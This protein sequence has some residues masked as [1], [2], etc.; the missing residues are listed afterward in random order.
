MDDYEA[1]VKLAKA[2]D[3]LLFLDFT[4]SDWCG[5]CI[6]LKS[7]VFDQR[8]FMKYADENLVLVELDFPKGKKLKKSLQKQNEELAK[9]YG[10][11][12]FPRIIIL[13]AKEEPVGMM[14]YQ[15][16]GPKPFIKRLK[17]FK[18]NGPLR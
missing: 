16:G 13:N 10:V 14:G 1:A 15:E 12:G 8:E 6:K 3:K 7:E 9:K 11:T 4:G 18:A 5:W 17:E 2:E